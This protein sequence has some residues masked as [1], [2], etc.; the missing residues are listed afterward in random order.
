[1]G[2]AAAISRASRVELSAYVLECGSAIVRALETAGDRGA[3]VSV[4]LEGNPYAGSAPT[5]DLTTRNRAAA[6]ELASHGV[7]VKVTDAGDLPVHMKA[8]LVDGTAYLDDRNWPSDGL[9]TIVAS[10]DGDDAAV[11]ASA[12]GGTPASDGHLATEK[13][14][15][16]ALEART[17]ERGSGDRVEVES[18]SF[19]YSSVSKALYARARGGAAVRLLVAQREY[20]EG[21]RTELASLRRLAGA[22]VEIRVVANDE[23]LCLAGDRGWIGSANATFEEHPMLDWGM[24]TRNAALLG[25]IGSAFDRNWALGVAVKL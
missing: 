10:S 9:D 19:G 18:E 25:G 11:V 8:A 5:D 7:A 22:G 4:R 3:R 17:I 13:R 15:A 12:L 16:L 2:L 20:A 23:K 24:A 6:A 21:G 1:M 14:R